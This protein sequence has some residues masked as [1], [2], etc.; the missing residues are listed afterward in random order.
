MIELERMENVFV[1]EMSLRRCNVHIMTHFRKNNG[2]TKW[3][4]EGFRGHTEWKGSLME[5]E[6][7]QA[8]LKVQQQAI[9]KHFRHS[10]IIYCQVQLSGENEI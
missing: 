10:A 2:V 1:K 7:T 3:E 4:L 6:E 5:A 8:K 9:M